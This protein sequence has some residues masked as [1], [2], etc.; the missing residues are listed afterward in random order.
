MF[1]YSGRTALV[2]GASSGIGA[3]FAR[4]LAQR[5]MNVALTARS[6]E[7]LEALAGELSQRHG[8]KAYALPADLR[9]AEAA[10]DLARRIAEQGLT[11]D[12][13]VNNAG[14][15]T[16]GPFETVAAERDHDE[17]M[18]NV[19]SVVS[20]SHAFMPAMLERRSGGIINVASVAAF[21][22][23]PYLSVYAA[24]KAFVLSFSVALREE[25]RD[26]NVRVL[27]FCPGTTETELFNSADAPEAKLGPARTP[28]QAVSTALRG[29]EQNRSVIVDGLKNSLLSHGPR[30]I[31]RW[32]AAR[33]AAATVR[34]RRPRSG[35]SK[36]V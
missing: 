14:F 6:T 29:L 24:T 28:Q 22:P 11:I 33:C 12:L 35:E 32:F 25:C 8:V 19:A 36:T 34:P 13:L 23:I 26:R 20:L 27:A 9:K 15:M 21:Q 4:A 1:D 17:V 31:P 2:T 5:G 30:V 3:E 7:K 10:S 16:Y 18:V